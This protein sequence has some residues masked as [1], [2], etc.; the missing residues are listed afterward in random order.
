MFMRAG[1]VVGQAGIF[2]AVTIL[3]VSQ[4]SGIGGQFAAE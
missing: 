1:F 2:Y 4:S 3:L